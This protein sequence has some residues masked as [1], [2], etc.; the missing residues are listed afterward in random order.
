MNLLDH[1][2]PSSRTLKAVFGHPVSGISDASRRVVGK[3]R[4][5][6]I[7]KHDLILRV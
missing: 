4:R 2:C 1:R 5:I 7:G 3:E 6:W